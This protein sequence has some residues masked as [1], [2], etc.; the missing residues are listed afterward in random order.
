[1]QEAASSALKRES[2]H[3]RAAAAVVEQQQAV[4]GDELKKKKERK[5]KKR[6]LGQG[7]TDGVGA[8]EHAAARGVASAKTPASSRAAAG[9]NQQEA[10][11]VVKKSSGRASSLARRHQ[12]FR[13]PP[14]GSVLP[15]MNEVERH[16]DGSV[17]KWLVA[18]KRVGRP[19]IH[20]S[21]KDQVPMPRDLPMVEGLKTLLPAGLSEKGLM[22]AS[23]AVGLAKALN[24]PQHYN[25]SLPDRPQK[26]N[27]LLSVLIH[28]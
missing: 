22:M 15:N 18:N 9:R 20:P 6:P 23:R 7:S 10:A 13:D 28:A 14:P 5:G 11:V 3:A 26:I 12:R 27:D 4:G 1:M 17:T 8:A 21:A 16:R 19:E 24:L 2:A 25:A